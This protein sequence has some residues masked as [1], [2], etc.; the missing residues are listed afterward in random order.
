[1]S[2]YG[3]HQFLDIFLL[4]AVFLNEIAHQLPFKMNVQLELG[5]FHRTFEQQ[6]CFESSN[7]GQSPSQSKKPSKQLTANVR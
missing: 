7:S 2:D 6:S 1:M 5:T 3:I 4:R